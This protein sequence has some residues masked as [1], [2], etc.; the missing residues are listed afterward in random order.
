ML[1]IKKKT[2]T[3]QFIGVL[4]GLGQRDLKLV[5]INSSNATT[6]YIP[7]GQVEWNEYYNA[8]NNYNSENKVV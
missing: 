8:Y 4:T 7:A 2:V 1:I 6:F 5:Q 3:G